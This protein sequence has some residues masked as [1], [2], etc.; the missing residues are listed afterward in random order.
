[1][2]KLSKIFP[3]NNPLKKALLKVL[4]AFPEGSAMDEFYE[5]ADGSIDAIVSCPSGSKYEVHVSREPDDDLRKVG[6]L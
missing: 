5:H 6:L 2:N 4:A 3:V 1:M